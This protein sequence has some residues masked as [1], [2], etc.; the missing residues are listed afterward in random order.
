[1]VRAGPPTCRAELPRTMRILERSNL[2][3]IEALSQR[4]GRTLSVVDLILANTVSVEIAAC[5]AEAV[6]RGASFLTAAQPGGAGKTA[7]LAALLGFLPGGVPIVTVDGPHV[8]AAAEEEET[9][10][11]YLAHEIGSGDWYG[12]IWG[13]VVARYLAL[14][15]G[16]HMVASCL[17]AD[18]IEELYDTLESAPLKVPRST[19][20]Q[21]DFILF[22]HVDRVDAEARGYRRRVAAVYQSDR[23]AGEHRPVFRWDRA[24]DAFEAVGYEP[25]G[26]GAADL[27]Q[28]LEG[29]A[30]SGLRDF[31]A[32]RHAYLAFRE[33]N[34]IA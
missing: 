13:P 22:V 6:G 28:F 27:A 19:L 29:M 11:C 21:I 34:R 9:P 26:S 33:E 31:A 3:Q 15:A 8:V 2:H 12:Y 7:L 18:T 16:P 25:A 20:L 4:G 17:H 32:L 14:A 23:E 1:M 5:V 24:R 30:A 10:Q